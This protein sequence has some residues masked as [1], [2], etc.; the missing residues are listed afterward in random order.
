MVPL[1]GFVGGAYK[2]PSKSAACQRCVNLYVEAVPNNA[3]A[4]AVLLGSPGFTG[5]GSFAYSLTPIRQN[6][7]YITS[8]NIMIIAIREVLRAYVNIVDGAL[9]P[10]YAGGDGMFATLDF[11]DEP[12]Y[13]PISMADNG[14][15][16]L[17]SSGDAVY[18]YSLEDI[19]AG[20]GSVA[21]GRITAWTY[22]GFTSVDYMA[23]RFLVNTPSDPTDDPTQNQ[24]RASPLVWDGTFSDWDPLA[25]ASADQSPDALLGLIVRG[26][27]LVLFSRQSTEFYYASDATPMPFVPNS[28]VCSS[29]GCGA[30]YSISKAEDT[31]FWLGAGKDGFNKIF[32]CAGFSPERI[33]NP[34]LEQEI[35]TYSSTDDALGFTYQKDGHTFYIITFQ[36]GNKTWQYD[37]TT[38][39][40]SEL[41]SLVAG[42][43]ERNRYVGLASFLGNIIALD[44]VSNGP[45]LL[46]NQIYTEGGESIVRTRSSPH[47]HASLNRVFFNKFQLDIETGIG[48]TSGQGS[49]PQVRLRWSNDGGYTWSDFLLRSMG[50][51]GDYLRRVIWNRLGQSRNRVWEISTSEPVPIRIL[52]AWFD[53]EEGEN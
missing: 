27:D 45:V 39:E 12:G 41:S 22:G 38:G 32:K 42:S 47:V 3:K 35:S 5:F 7:I 48:L 18:Q 23:G 19:S 40:W 1:N 52:G 28:S 8:N 46:S 13:G 29:I 21:G 10:W 17:V 30:K 51:I 14:L 6:G 36:T 50:K 26:N 43:Q 20:G 34:A 11:V 53:A 31:I 9:V 2:L 33:S 16:L 44:R 37:L 4:P 49:D 25:F 24:F 15:I